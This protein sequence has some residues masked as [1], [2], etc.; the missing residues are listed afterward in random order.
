M[1]KLVNWIFAVGP[2]S[3]SSPPSTSVKNRLD[4][5]RSRVGR[6]MW[7]NRTGAGARLPSCC[8]CEW[9]F[10]SIIVFSL[11]SCS[12]RGPT[13][14]PN[15]P[16]QGGRGQLLP[17]LIPP[18]R[19]EGTRYLIHG[20]SQVWTLKVKEPLRLDGIGPLIPLRTMYGTGRM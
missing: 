18:A 3:R 6:L 14:L 17:C 10:V 5:A 15:P 2:S 4:P 13:P 8:G 9:L 16:P 12:E 7:L 20:A 19:G 1:A 11:P